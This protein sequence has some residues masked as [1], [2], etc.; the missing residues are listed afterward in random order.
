MLLGIFAA[1][2]ERNLGMSS[3]GKVKPTK[4]VSL[5]RWSVKD[6]K[7][8]NP[9]RTESER[10]KN[11]AQHEAIINAGFVPNRKAVVYLR[12]RQNLILANR[13]ISKK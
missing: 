6:K 8:R 7:K 11:I 5:L 3:I 2:S 9:S 12:S 1:D 10:R 4:A 13:K